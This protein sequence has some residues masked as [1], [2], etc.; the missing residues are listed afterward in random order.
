MHDPTEMQR[1]VEVAQLNA[2]AGSREA[3]QSRY[4]QVW[5]TQELQRDFEVLSFL[6]PYVVVKRRSDGRKGS[7]RFQ[8][9]PRFYFE[10]QPE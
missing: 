10:F 3:L 6:S 7:L 2:Q 5:D 1:R 8:H 9:N 4:G